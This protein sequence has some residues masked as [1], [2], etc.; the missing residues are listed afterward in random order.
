MG[1]TEDVFSLV[2]PKSDDPE[3]IQFFEM[4]T[5]PRSLFGYDREHVIDA[6]HC[7]D[8]L[9]QNRIA[10]LKKEN[11]RDREFRRGQVEQKEDTIVR[12]TKRAETR[13]IVDWN[14]PG[15]EAVAPR[16]RIDVILG[17]LPEIQQ[18]LDLLIKRAAMEARRICAEARRRADELLEENRR[19]LAEE[20]RQH[21]QAL[22]KMSELKR[23]YFADL[24]AMQAIL[25]D[26]QLEA[27]N[28][29]K[30]LEGIREEKHWAQG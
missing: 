28:F 26:M 23:E 25:T 8:K 16:R 11:Q 13:S 5:L 7:L 3:V 29:R 17:I 21:A 1:N 14:I 24:S 18:S 9:Y 12:L 30:R 19:Q 10:E 4:L 22:E 20:R 15:G 6:L 27:D 2:Q